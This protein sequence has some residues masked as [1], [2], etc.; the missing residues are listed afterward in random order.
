MRFFSHRGPEQRQGRDQRLP[1][2]GLWKQESFQS[3]GFIFHE[4]IHL[5]HLTQSRPRMPLVCHQLVDVSL[6]SWA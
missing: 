5:Y 1:L 2:E 4:F 6:A 3:P